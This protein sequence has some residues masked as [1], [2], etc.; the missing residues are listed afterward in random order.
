MIGRGRTKGR[1]VAVVRAGK[2]RRRAERGER[3]GQKVA[4]RSASDWSRRVAQNFD[5]VNRTVDR[6]SQIAA[7]VCR[8][9]C[10][11][12]RQAQ[13]G[14]LKAGER[15]IEIGNVLVAKENRRS[16]GD[17]VKVGGLP[18]VL[19]REILRAVALDEL[20]ERRESLSRRRVSGDE[21]NGE[22]EQ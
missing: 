10:C 17:R 21:D 19:K 3:D 7:A 22:D 13:H 20:R 12:R 5:A 8:R 14:F 16:V 11:G 6:L 15:R 2:S 4:A 18:V 9:R 1:R